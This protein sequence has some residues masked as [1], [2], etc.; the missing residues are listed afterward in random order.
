MKSYKILCGVC[1]YVYE[2]WGVYN[3]KQKHYITHSEG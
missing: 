2:I 3:T 1:V